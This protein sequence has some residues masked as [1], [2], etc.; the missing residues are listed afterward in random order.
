MRFVWLALALFVGCDSRAPSTNEPSTD[1]RG[2][3]AG[4]EPVEPPFAVRGDLSGLLL[5]YFD[6]E[7]P[8]RATSLAEVPSELRQY[9]LVDSLE[10]PPDQREPDHVFV[11]DLRVMDQ[12]RYPVH[13][14]PRA[15]FDLLVDRLTGVEP[16]SPTTLAAAPIVI[17]GA[18]WCSACRA[19]KG[20]FAQRGVDVQDRDIEREPGAR[21]EMQAKARAQ[22]V[23]TSG[24]PVIDVRGRLTTGFDPN[25][26]ERLLA[27]TT[28]RTL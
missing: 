17:Y 10:I 18:S 25:T 4:A 15:A 27:E 6:A 11:A 21:A 3:P 14:Y 28:P 24:I 2:L 22:G 19:A 26:L 23:S 7:G 20:W 8:H 12:G 9:V 1:G 13:R 16:S 5:T